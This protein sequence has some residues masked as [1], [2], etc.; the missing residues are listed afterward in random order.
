MSSF[1]ELHGHKKK[2]HW[3][4]LYPIWSIISLNNHYFISSLFYQMFFLWISFPLAV[5]YLMLLST[6]FQLLYIVAVS[7]IGRVHWSCVRKLCDLPNSIMLYFY[8]T[9]GRHSH[10]RIIS[11]RGEVWTHKTSLT[12]PLF[13]LS[14][15]T[16]PG[17]CTVM[18][19]CVRDIVFASF[20]DFSVGFRNFSD[21][22]TVL[23]V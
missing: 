5:C 20:Y 21:S 10:N 14:A 22:V 3:F 4:L 17:K 13:L 8:N 6:L 23:T 15:C 18:Y 1:V 9:C 2:C 11:L 7:F 19:F 16:K 12:P